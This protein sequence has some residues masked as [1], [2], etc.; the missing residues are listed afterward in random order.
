MNENNYCLVTF[1]HKKKINSYEKICLKQ[2]NNKFKDI[3]K[4][5]V[6]FN[7][8]EI[9]K[10]IDKFFFKFKKIFFNRKYFKSTLTY[11]KLCSSIEFYEKFTDYKYILICHLDTYVNYNNI[12][13][14]IKLDY[15]YIGAPSAYKSF[16][17]KKK[18]TRV[19]LFCNGGFCLRKV[20]HFLMVLKS[21]KLKLPINKYIFYDFIKSRKNFTNFIKLFFQ[22]LAQT[23]R[24]RGS[25]FAEKFYANEDVFWSYYAKFFYENFHIPNKSTC[26]NFAFD[27]N[28]S[29]FFQ[30]NNNKIPMAFH[31]YYEYLEFLNNHQKF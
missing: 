3:D 25:Y 28:P 19:K 11:N 7:N 10:L 21:N 17:D 4:F 30:K 2:I 27:G 14:Y 9:E 29:F 16:F 13:Q 18:L 1:L 22:T 6:T 23:S 31:G 20:D 12:N 15:S 5:V 26:L 8:E 24:S